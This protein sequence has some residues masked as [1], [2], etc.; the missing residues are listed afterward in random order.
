MPSKVPQEPAEIESDEEEMMPMGGY[1]GEM[2][3]RKEDRWSSNP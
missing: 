1:P 2:P 3:E